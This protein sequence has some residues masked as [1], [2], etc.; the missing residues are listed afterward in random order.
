MF[1]IFQLGDAVGDGSMEGDPDGIKSFSIPSPLSGVYQVVGV[2]TGS[3]TY[4]LDLETFGPGV[5]RNTQPI[6]EQYPR[7]FGSPTTSP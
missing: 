4:E 7:D 5:T 2:G 1:E 6:Q 3:G